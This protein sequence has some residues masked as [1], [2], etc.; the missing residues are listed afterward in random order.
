MESNASQA[1]EAARLWQNE[2]ARSEA[3]YAMLRSLEKRGSFS[4][5]NWLSLLATP[6]A[7]TTAQVIDLY[8]ELRDGTWRNELE[9]RQEF[10]AAFPSCAEQLPPPTPHA[11]RDYWEQGFFYA[12]MRNDADLI[13]TGL[14]ELAAGGVGLAEL[15]RVDRAS[16][17]ENQWF[18]AGDR[19]PPEDAL[20]FSQLAEAVGRPELT[21]LFRI[22]T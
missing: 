9:W 12:L 5:T 21:A 17:R 7:L 18:P 6:G 14:A 1:A 2:D 11:L 13:R 3:M 10:A 22:G 4:L 20:T 15:Q 19:T 16:I 8:T